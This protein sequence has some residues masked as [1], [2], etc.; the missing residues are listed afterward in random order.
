MLYELREEDVSFLKK[1]LECENSFFD[2]RPNTAPIRKTILDALKRPIEK[3]SSTKIET[4]DFD[5]VI[6]VKGKTILKKIVP[7]K[8]DSPLDIPL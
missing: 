3:S 5:S 4:H 6:F 7:R 8:E 1:L 2:Y